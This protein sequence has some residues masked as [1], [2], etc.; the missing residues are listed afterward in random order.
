NIGAIRATED[1]GYELRL[2]ALG[3]CS[4]DSS[5][6]LEYTPAPDD[7]GDAETRNIIIGAIIGA[8]SLIALTYLVV[9]L[10]LRKH[11]R[12][13]D[14]IL[15]QR[16]GGITGVSHHRQPNHPGHRPNDA[17]YP[18]YQLPGP[19]NPNALEG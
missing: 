4:T 10:Y 12:T 2:V 1:H 19:Y 13:F 3:C 16:R 8:M 17:S 11:G 14:D 7:A 5:T 6:S 9:Y 18:L 15:L